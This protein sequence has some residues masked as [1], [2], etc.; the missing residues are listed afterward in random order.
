M[1]FH[2]YQ[3]KELFAEVGIPVP[4]GKIARTADEAVEAAKALDG[5]ARGRGARP[6]AGPEG[7]AR[8]GAARRAAEALPR[9]AAAAAGPAAALL[10]RAHDHRPPPPGT[11]AGRDHPPDGLGCRG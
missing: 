4:A 9:P 2:E 3:A 10:H 8:A 6:G 11:A 5:A 1:N 7:L